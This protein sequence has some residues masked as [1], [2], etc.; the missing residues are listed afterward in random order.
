MNHP[1]DSIPTSREPL[2][3]SQG[4]LCPRCKVRRNILA[5]K[6]LQTVEEY[7]DITAPIYKCPDN[8]CKFVFAPVSEVVYNFFDI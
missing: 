2:V 8:H 4:M 6:R 7:E 1:F 3:N 5:F